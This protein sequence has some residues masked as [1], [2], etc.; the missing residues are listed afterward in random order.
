[1]ITELRQPLHLE[2]PKGPGWAYF[3]ID[4]GTDHHLLWVVFLD[5]DGTCWQVP[6]P[7]IRLSANWSLERRYSPTP[8]SGETAA[9]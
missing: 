4:Y 7:E 6:N 3:I 1:V 5:A 8:K 2:T 9:A